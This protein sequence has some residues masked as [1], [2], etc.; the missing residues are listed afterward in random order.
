MKSEW[1]FLTALAGALTLVAPGRGQTTT[2]NAKPDTTTTAGKRKPKTTR[3]S[4]KQIADAK[5]KG[6][7]WANTRAKV[8]RD[9]DSRLY[10]RTRHGKFM[11]LDEATKAGFTAA[12]PATGRGS[13]T[14]A[15]P[16]H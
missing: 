1:I 9:A 8:Y 6:M 13:A 7:V 5:A 11:T 16:A 2:T 15:T 12:R 14:Q 4:A 3:P 10:G